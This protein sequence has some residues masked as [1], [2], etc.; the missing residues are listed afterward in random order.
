[1]RANKYMSSSRLCFKM[2]SRTCFNAFQLPCIHAVS[3]AEDIYNLGEQ[4]DNIH[5][6]LISSPLY[7]PYQRLYMGGGRT[8]RVPQIHSIQLWH[9]EPTELPDT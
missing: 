9:L 6:I 5:N 7:D 8:Q 1:M 3:Y 4:L 2:A